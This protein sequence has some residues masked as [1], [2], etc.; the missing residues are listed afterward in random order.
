LGLFE[1]RRPQME[2]IFKSIASSSGPAINRSDIYLAWDFTIASE[3]NLS[4]RMLSMRDDAFSS[5]NGAIP[6][7]KIT[8]VTDHPSAGVYRRV[9]GTVDVPRYV[10]TDQ[11]GAF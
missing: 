2:G 7:Y 1:T 6:S 4:E 5:L 9:Q 8:T 10:S 3:R 11:P